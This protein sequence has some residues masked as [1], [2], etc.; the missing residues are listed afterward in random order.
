MDHENIKLIWI[1]KASKEELAAVL[2]SRFED[3][4]IAMNRRERSRSRDEPPSR[5]RRPRGTAPPAS[6]IMDSIPDTE[7]QSL[8]DEKVIYILAWNRFMSCNCDGIEDDVKL[9]NKLNCL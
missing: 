2:G 6:G 5:P 4:C 1:T 8:L 7:L 9:S 3:S